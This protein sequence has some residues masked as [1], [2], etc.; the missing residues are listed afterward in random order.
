MQN[1]LLVDDDQVSNFLSKKMLERI[2]YAGQI[3]ATQNGKEAIELLTEHWR[4]DHPLPNVI[5]LDLNMPIMTGFDFIEAFN[6]LDFPDKENVK[7]IIVTISLDYMDWMKSQQ[8]GIKRYLSKPL[9][10]NALRTILYN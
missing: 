9:S 5:L 6:K 10:E 4:Q 8:M 7:I 3:H 2:G 1:V